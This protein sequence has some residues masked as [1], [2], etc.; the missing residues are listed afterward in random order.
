MVTSKQQS[1]VRLYHTIYCA[2]TM[3]QTI[4]CPTKPGRQNSSRGTRENTSQENLIL[5]GLMKFYMC[6]CFS[7]Q[8]CIF[9]S[10]HINNSYFPLAQNVTVKAQKNPFPLVC[11]WLHFL[12][13][14]TQ[15]L[16]TS[17]F[18]SKHL[19]IGPFDSFQAQLPKAQ[20]TGLEDLH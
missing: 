2:N 15:V 6:N 7:L 20:L 8:T 12:L 10:H 11:K 14:T 9:D 18:C 1:R 3:W 19:S 4:P 16:T 5:S 13:K 17:R